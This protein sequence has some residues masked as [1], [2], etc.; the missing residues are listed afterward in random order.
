M[1]DVDFI[2]EPDESGYGRMILKGVTE[3]IAFLDSQ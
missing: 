3:V 1:I 2:T